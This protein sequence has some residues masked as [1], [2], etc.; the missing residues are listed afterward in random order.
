[1]N[2][3]DEKINKI[4]SLLGELNDLIP[5]DDVTEDLVLNE[6]EKIFK[7]DYKFTFDYYKNCSLEIFKFIIVL[8]RRLNKE[9]KSKEFI[10][11]L[12]I[13][14]D[15]FEIKKD[16]LYAIFSGIIQI[17]DKEYV[18]NYLFNNYFIDETSTYEFF[19]HIFEWDFY[20]I[21]YMLIEIINKF[22][23]NQL[24]ELFLKI[25]KEN[26]RYYLFK[27]DFRIFRKIKKMNF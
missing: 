27:R 14:N 4:N 11:M 25:D 17:E 12:I 10:E 8:I 26:K 2:K 15:E 18:K 21:S 16:N 1:M 3:N 7:E 22:K 20:Q 24:K 5:E 19:K 13:K 9:F 6:L 23:S